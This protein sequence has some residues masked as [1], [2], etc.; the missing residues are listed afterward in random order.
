MT[1]IISNHID[2]AGIENSNTGKSCA[3]IN[4]NR[5]WI[6]GIGTGND[7]ECGE[8]AEYHVK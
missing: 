1:A 7:C 3:K 4:P 6:V 8:E 2:L 5:N